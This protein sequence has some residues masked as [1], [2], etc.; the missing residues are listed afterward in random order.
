MLYTSL[1]TFEVEL[2]GKT[3]RQLYI[4]PVD[5]MLDSLSIHES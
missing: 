3:V 5:T 1:R 4:P 2:Q